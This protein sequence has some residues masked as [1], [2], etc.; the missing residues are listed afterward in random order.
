MFEGSEFPKSQR[1]INNIKPQR[2]LKST[3]AGITDNWSVPG[4]TYET[5]GGAIQ[6]FMPIR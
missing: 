1:Q 2:A 5:E 4:R 3:A 6:Y